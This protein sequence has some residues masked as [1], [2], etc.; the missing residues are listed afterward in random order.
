MSAILATTAGKLAVVAAVSVKALVAP[1]P[2]TSS[3]D[4]G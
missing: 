3:S 4:H 2:P 1:Q